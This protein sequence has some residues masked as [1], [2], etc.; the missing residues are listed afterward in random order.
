M[1]GSTLAALVGVTLTI[2]AMPAQ[3]AWKSY[4]NKDLALYFM[5]PGEVKTSEGTF[6]GAIA[7]P[8]QTILYRSVEDNIEYRVTVMS[9]VQ[10]QAEGATI[11]GEREYMFQDGKKVLKDVFARAG[12]GKDAVYG[13]KIV[14]DLPDSK[15]RTTGAFFFTKGRLISLEATVLPAHGDLASP[16]PDRFIDSISFVPSRAEA[17]VIELETPKFE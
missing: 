3:A 8:R 2:V 15:G 17:G 1:R 14:V 7:G 11:L 10:A 16:D 12:S 13:R 9:F 6:R 5:A 4:V